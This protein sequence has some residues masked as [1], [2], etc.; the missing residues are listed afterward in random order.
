M[1]K[2]TYANF[3]KGKIQV[4]KFKYETLLVHHYSMAQVS[5]ASHTP[6]KHIAHTHKVRGSWAFTIPHTV[7]GP[8]NTTERHPAIWEP[9]YTERDAVQWVR[10][11]GHVLGTDIGEGRESASCRRWH[12]YLGLKED[13]EKRWKGNPG[14]E[15]IMGKTMKNEIT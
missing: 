7:I 5:F 9:D 6:H 8:R 1:C 11:S 15:N 14:R 13:R 3:L 10:H 4:L 2:Q 12:L